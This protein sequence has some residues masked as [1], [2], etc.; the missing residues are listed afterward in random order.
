MLAI[1]MVAMVGMVGCDKDGRDEFE[2]KLDGSW[3]TTVNSIEYT[4]TFS[5]TYSLTV[6]A[7]GSKDSG[8]YSWNSETKVLNTDLSVA[9]SASY[10]LS[11]SSA[12]EFEAKN[13]STGAK[14]KFKR[15][16]VID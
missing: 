11:F 5:T 4:Y 3:V 10:D 12:N 1:M 8:K 7:S 2:N 6:F 16:G 14:L 9:G 15:S 13:R